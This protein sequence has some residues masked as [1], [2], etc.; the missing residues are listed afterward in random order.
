[1]TNKIYWFPSRHS[2]TI[3]TYV[4]LWNCN[5]VVIYETEQCFPICIFVRMLQCL[6]RT[7]EAAEPCIKLFIVS[8]GEKRSEI[9]R[10]RIRIKVQHILVYHRSPFCR[11]C[12]P[13]KVLIK[14]GKYTL[15]LDALDYSNFV[16]MEQSVAKWS[17]LHAIQSQN[18]EKLVCQRKAAHFPR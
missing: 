7:Y 5:Q 1:M 18:H 12:R 3:E 17:W 9:F 10:N 8:N 11:N 13:V 2:R 4:V 6:T 14:I 16:L 15:A